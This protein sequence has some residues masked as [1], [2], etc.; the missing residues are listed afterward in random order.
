MAFKK[1]DRVFG[2]KLNG[3]PIIGHVQCDQVMHNELVAVRC[4]FC[5][6]EYAIGEKLLQKVDAEKHGPEI[7]HLFKVVEEEKAWSTRA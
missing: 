2:T 5:G 3:E 4:L 1:D 6:N 7:A